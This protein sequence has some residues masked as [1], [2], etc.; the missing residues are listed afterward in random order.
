MACIRVC[1]EGVYYDSDVFEFGIFLAPFLPY[2]FYAFT[3]GVY[4]MSTKGGSM[5]MLCGILLAG[6]F[7]GTLR[8]IIGV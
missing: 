1:K 4:I 8:V 3:V 2:D 6:G 7:V 5:R